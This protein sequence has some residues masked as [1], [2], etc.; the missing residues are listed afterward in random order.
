MPR[1]ISPAEHELKARLQEVVDGKYDK[2]KSLFIDE[3]HNI[4]RPEPEQNAEEE[5]FR[6]DYHEPNL[7]RV[8]PND[9][10]IF[11]VKELDKL[12]TKE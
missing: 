9:L 8:K 1:T 5:A 6:F 4:T 11:D 7:F 2:R 3:D 12:T 10:S